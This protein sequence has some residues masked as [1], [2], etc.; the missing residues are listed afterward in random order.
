M[1]RAIRAGLRVLRAEDDQRDSDDATELY[2]RA[3]CDDGMPA[4]WGPVMPS[5]D[6]L[7]AALRKVD[8]ACPCRIAAMNQCSAFVRRCACI[9]LGRISEDGPI[10]PDWKPEQDLTC[11]WPGHAAINSLADAAGRGRG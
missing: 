1:L 6:D 11:L 5:A 4:A 3:E 9:R 8:E 2:L 7:R 10:A